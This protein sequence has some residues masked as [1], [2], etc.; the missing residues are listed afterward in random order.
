MTYLLDHLPWFV[1]GLILGGLF[2]R[3]WV[4]EHYAR[5][6]TEVILEARKQN[7]VKP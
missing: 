2:V 6:L 7:E 5:T 4:R 1:A 3:G